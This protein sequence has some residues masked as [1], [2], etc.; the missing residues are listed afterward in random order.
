[1][2]K[3]PVK[4]SFFDKLRQPGWAALKF[5]WVCVFRFGSVSENR[6]DYLAVGVD[7][8]NARFDKA[9]GLRRADTVSC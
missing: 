8:I 4:T 1:M 2:K 6:V 3:S 9:V 5:V 7:F